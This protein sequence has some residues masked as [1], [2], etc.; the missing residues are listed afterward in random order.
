M[1]TLLLHQAAYDRMKRRLKSFSQGVDFVTVT[2]DEIYRRPATNEEID[3][4]QPH[5]AFAN[6]DIWY[7]KAGGRFVKAV[8]TSPHLDWIQSSAAGL[9][10]PVLVSMGQKAGRYTTCHVQAEAMSE[11]ALW[12]ALDFM[13]KG[14]ERRTNKAAGLWRRARSREINGSHWLIVGLGAI[15]QAVGRRIKA[16]GGQVTGVRRSGGTCDHADTVLTAVTPEALGQA[17]VVLLCLPHTTATEN[18]AD[19]AFFAA[20]KPDA[21]FLNLGRGALV[22]E[23]ALLAALDAGCPAMAGLD[24]TRAEPLPQDDPLWAHDKVMITAHDSSDTPGTDGRIDQVF[25]DNLARWVRDEPLH[26]IVDRSAFENAP[27]VDWSAR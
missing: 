24:V 1:K 25:L 10:H 13:R 26:D 15:G 2:D 6:S 3:L 5:A 27:D 18:M 21:L 19:A 11:W 20:M 7:G 23:A 17:D 9:E 8:M 22:D 14:D 4:P 16:L 12:M